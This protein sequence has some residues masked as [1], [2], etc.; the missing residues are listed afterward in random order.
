MVT[1]D[2]V[3][4]L[5]KTP[6]VALFAKP[7]MGKTR[8][9]VEM[10]TRVRPKKTLIIGPPLVLST[11]WVQ[12][13]KMKDLDFVL[14]DGS[15][16]KRKEKLISPHDIYMISA[17]LIPWIVPELKDF[18]CVI[19][20]EST[21][22]KSSK[23]N[24]FKKL[25]KPIQSIPRRVLMT[26]TP[27]SNGIQNIWS[28]MFL[29]DG[30]ERLGKRHGE[31]MFRWFVRVS[32]WK[33]IPRV[34]A[35]DEIVKIIS[36][37]VINVDDVEFAESEYKIFNT[38]LNDQSKKF[39]MEIQ[40]DLV[41]SWGESDVGIDNATVALNKLCQIANGAMYYEDDVIHI[42][43]QKYSALRLIELQSQSLIVVYNYKFQ[44]DQLLQMGYTH[45]QTPSDIDDWNN[46]KIKK[47]TLHPRS[48]GYGLNLQ[49]G[50][51][52]LVWLGLTWDFEL[53]AQ[54]NARLIRR[55]QTSKV[56]I[57]HILA[58]KTVDFIIYSSLCNKDMTQ[59]DF[60]NSI[61]LILRS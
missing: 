35:M 32:E 28:Q 18:D 13:L 30:G 54:T 46:G 6:R 52:S 23:S 12:E 14:C 27:I 56:T 4:R 40:N 50:G 7:G 33:W 44:L 57:W 5:I 43:E 58:Q 53:Y 31:F 47:L 21:M 19:I 38:W 17:N 61:P 10:L 42:H 59:R 48:A 26:G 29:L 3:E 11:T 8:W 39:Y 37:I 9:V 15:P 60:L 55:G 41:S 2:V 49:F 36:D 16:Q 25:K 34:G 51:S 24:R 22:F 45:L 1:L 20:D